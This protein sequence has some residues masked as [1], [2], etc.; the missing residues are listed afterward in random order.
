MTNQKLMNQFLQKHLLFTRQKIPKS[1]FQ[2]HKL[3]YFSPKT[4]IGRL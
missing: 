1:F 2:V 4:I 3:L